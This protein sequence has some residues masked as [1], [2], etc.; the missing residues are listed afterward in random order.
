MVICIEADL[1]DF[2][3][4]SISKFRFSLAS[5]HILIGS[6]HF[7]LKSSMMVALRPEQ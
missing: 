3:S 7:T 2:I 5:I 1:A 6:I 4:S